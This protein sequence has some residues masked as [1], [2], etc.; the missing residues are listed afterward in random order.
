[1]SATVGSLVLAGR[2]AG[3]ADRPAA[4]LSPGSADVVPALARKVNHYSRY[5]FLRFEKEGNVEKGSWEAGSS[6]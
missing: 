5:G 1:M 2:L 4:L 3:R 6:R